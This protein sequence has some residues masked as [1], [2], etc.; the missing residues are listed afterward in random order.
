[1]EK[2]ASKRV[3]EI[4]RYANTGIELC[5]KSLTK[6]I[7]NLCRETGLDSSVPINFTKTLMLHNTKV[8]KHRGRFFGYVDETILCDRIYWTE[9][10]EGVF[11]V[12]FNG[13]C[14][15]ASFQMTLNDLCIIYNELLQVLKTL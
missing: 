1:M 12:G 3:K 14:N 4:K 13:D 7:I 6:S 15:K 2:N 8:E 10:R 5:R 11:L 9:D